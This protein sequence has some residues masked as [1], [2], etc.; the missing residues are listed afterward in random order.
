M[1]CKYSD[2]CTPGYD[3][4]CEEDFPS[5]WDLY[6]IECDCYI[7]EWHDRANMEGLCL[8]S[9]F[10][11]WHGQGQDKLHEISTK[12]SPFLTKLKKESAAELCAR[13][14]FDEPTEEQKRQNLNDNLDYFFSQVK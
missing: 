5:Q 7:P 9:F 13:L 2:Q 14:G 11:K 8:K 1:T 4:F 3:C 10:R 6:S 12:V